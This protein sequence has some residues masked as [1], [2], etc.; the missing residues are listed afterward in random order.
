MPG[1]L[2]YLRLL[3]RNEEARSAFLAA[4][5]LQSTDMREQSF[6]DITRDQRP[7]ASGRASQAGCMAATPMALISALPAYSNHLRDHNI[8]IRS[9]RH[10]PND[11]DKVQNSLA[12]A[13]W[14]GLC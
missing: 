2:F 10:D 5:T 4:S 13:E 3:S 14:S 7:G 8:M 12:C 1:V 6:F 9:A 11:Q